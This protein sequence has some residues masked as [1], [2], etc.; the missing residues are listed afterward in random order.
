MSKN[1]SQVAAEVDDW[2]SCL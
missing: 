1:Y 2:L